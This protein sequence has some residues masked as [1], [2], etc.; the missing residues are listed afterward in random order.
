M[1]IP[2]ASNFLH[3]SLNQVSIIQL[4]TLQVAVLERS[5]LNFHIIF[6]SPASPVYQMAETTKIKH[7][8]GAAT[9]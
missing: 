6:N 5:V 4:L 3:L 1:H 7:V 8:F 9:P 2:S